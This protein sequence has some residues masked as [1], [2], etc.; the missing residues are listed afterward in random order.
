[1]CNSRR[2]VR[3]DVSQRATAQL[4]LHVVAGWH[5]DED[6]SV[7]AG[8][9]IGRNAGMLERLPRHFQQQSLLRIHRGRL[10]RRN[11]EERSVEFVDRRLDEPRM[12]RGARTR[13]RRGG[14]YKRAV[15]PACRGHRTDP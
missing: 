8:Q 7:A 15:V 9:P 11:A 2:V 4:Q 10:A 14:I 3:I 1:M 13:P 5:A 6:A 12:L